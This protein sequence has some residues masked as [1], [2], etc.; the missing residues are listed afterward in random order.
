MAY[1]E[2]LAAAEA[3]TIKALWIVA[4]NPFH[5]WID[6]GRLAALREKL[7]FLVV[8][9]MYHNTETAREA[10]LV[11]PAAGW[12]EKEGTFIN[13]ERRFGLVK[14]VSKAPGTALSDFAIFKLVAH[15]WGCAAQFHEWTSP[16]ATFQI[17]KRLL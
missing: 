17:L 12:G 6:S 7:D 15:Y 9:D 11:L 5:S 14:K 1:D 8:Q 10:D 3:G 16:E 13:S 2:I 4:T